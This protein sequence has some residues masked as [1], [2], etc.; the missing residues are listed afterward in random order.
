MTKKDGRDWNSSEELTAGDGGK[1]YFAG[2]SVGTPE[3]EDCAVVRDSNGSLTPWGYENGRWTDQSTEMDIAVYTF[4]TKQNGADW[5]SISEL[6]DAN[7]YYYSEGQRTSL[8]GGDF[9]LVK[10]KWYSSGVETTPENYDY[11]YVD[12]MQWMY[13]NG[14]W[15]T[16]G[17]KQEEYSSTIEIP[18]EHQ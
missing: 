7:P 11:A 4:V 10:G 12:G 14:I 1:W 17:Q 13:D 5:D 18:D 2:L 16:I 8:H 6:T 15:R 3:D 9:A